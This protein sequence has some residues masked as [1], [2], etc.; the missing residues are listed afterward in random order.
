M[1]Q[2]TQ[3]YP[4]LNSSTHSYISV[5]GWALLYSNIKLITNTWLI[6]RDRTFVCCFPAT[7][8]Q[9]IRFASIDKAHK[10]HNH[11]KFCTHPKI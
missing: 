7:S 9:K 11:N 3:H 4:V 8:C 6:I 10:G 5:F 2:L 1:E